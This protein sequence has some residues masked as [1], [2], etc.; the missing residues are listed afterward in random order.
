MPNVPTIELL[1]GSC[2]AKEK[3]VWQENISRHQE[4]SKQRNNSDVV[5]CSYELYV[6]FLLDS[7][8]DW[9]PRCNTGTVT[10]VSGAVVPNVK[11]TA[12]NQNSGVATVRPTS[13][14]GLFEINPI[15]PG[16]YTVTAT[17]KGFQTFKQQNLVVDALKVTGLNISLAIGG[18][19]QTITVTGAPPALNT[20]SATLG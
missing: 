1:Q 7:G 19:D 10:D 8:P 9:R 18:Q 5:S 16:T 20:T 14:A 6:V 12:T 4:S 17:A 13:S 15:I 2:D 3:S 11:V